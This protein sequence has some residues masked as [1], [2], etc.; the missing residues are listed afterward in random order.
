MNYNF[1]LVEYIYRVIFFEEMIIFFFK[2]CRWIC[3]SFLNF[4]DMCS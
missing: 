4:E 1:I 3:G 2:V